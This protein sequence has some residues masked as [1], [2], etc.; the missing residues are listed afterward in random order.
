MIDLIALTD[1]IT[2]TLRDIPS[3]VAELGGVPEGIYGYIDE[4]PAKNSLAKA[5]YQMPPGTVL[6]AWID[7][8]LSEG[9]MTG[10]IHRFNFHVKA[11]KGESPLALIKLIVDGTAVGDDLR[12][13]Y[14][15]VL[16]GI[17]PAELVT[18]SRNTD[19]EGIDYPIIQMLF[20]EAS[21][22]NG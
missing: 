18:I 13:R 21:D 12:W 2:G 9:D 15:C 20:Q 19:S 7:S 8:G 16:P 22:T 1:A 11:V 10:F 3:L 4:T 14:T 17:M 6:V 5:V